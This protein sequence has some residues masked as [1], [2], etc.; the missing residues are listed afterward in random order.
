MDFTVVCNMGV[1][2]GLLE[3]ESLGFEVVADLLDSI[4]A[5]EDPRHPTISNW[6]SVVPK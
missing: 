6:Q 4:V 3:G 1:A 5:V 2:L